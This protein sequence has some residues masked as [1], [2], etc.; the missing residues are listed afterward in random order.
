MEVGHDV[1]EGH[2]HAAGALFLQLETLFS[3]CDARLQLAA[4]HG[5]V[6]R[7]HL[8]HG[9]H[10]DTVLAPALVHGEGAG[11]PFGQRASGADADALAFQVVDGPGASI[12]DHEAH[13]ARLGGKRGDGMGGHSLD[14]IAHAGP[15]ADAEIERAGGKGLLHLSVA[16]EGRNCRVEPFGQEKPLFLAEF[17]TGHGEGR[18]DRLADAHRLRGEGARNRQRKGA[19]REER[20]AR[21]AERAEW[22]VHCV[23]PCQ[24][25]SRLMVARLRCRAFSGH[26]QQRAVVL[27]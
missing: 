2:Q 15:R 21:Q 24:A 18:I 8:A 22:A 5:G 14:R 9:H 3:R 20:A 13:V 26:R 10:F 25:A 23:S 12:H 6:A 7:A 17:E 19:R 1:A 11:E 4:F 27:N 16:A